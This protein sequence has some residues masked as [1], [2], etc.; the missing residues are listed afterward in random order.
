MSTVG[1]WAKMAEICRF[2]DNPDFR[3]VGPPHAND[4][5]CRS[6]KSTHDARVMEDLGYKH[7]KERS[8][9]SLDLKQGRLG[10]MDQFCRFRDNPYFRHVGPPH[11]NAR[12]RG[13]VRSTQGARV[14]KLIGR[15]HYLRRSRSYL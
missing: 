10:K 9:P 15:D 13:S 6:I 12:E 1:D 5:I 11:A 2:R 3:D 7:P 8:R 14:M 4:R